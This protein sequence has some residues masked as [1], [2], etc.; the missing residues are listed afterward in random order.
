MFSMYTRTAKAK[1]RLTAT[2]KITAGNWNIIDLKIIRKHKI[3]E[4]PTTN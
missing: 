2:T 4:A 3:F 1:P